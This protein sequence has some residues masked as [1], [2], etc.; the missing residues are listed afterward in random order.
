MVTMTAFRVFLSAVSSEFASARDALT[1]DFGAR[2]VL[3]RV[4]E[5]FLPARRL[6]TLLEALDGDIQT[7]EA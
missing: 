5:Q 2:D 7:C 3:V 4:Q 6:H 1:D